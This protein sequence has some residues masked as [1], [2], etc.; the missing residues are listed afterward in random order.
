MAPHEPAK[1]K[2]VAEQTI[3][4]SA[5]GNPPQK[6]GFR[7]GFLTALMSKD[8]SACATSA[9]KLCSLSAADQDQ[10]VAACR[11]LTDAIYEG[12]DVTSEILSVKQQ[13]LGETLLLWDGDSLEALAVC[14]CGEGTEAG[15]HICSV[16]FAA[17]QPE[18]AADKAFDRLMDAIEGLWRSSDPWRVSLRE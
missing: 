15:K 9:R 1:T 7:P 17:V 4:H 3:A 16:K 6:F 13:N 8:A 5:R 2:P 14:P 10:A 18:F 11:K 12:L